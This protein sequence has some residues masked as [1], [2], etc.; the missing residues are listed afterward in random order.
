MILLLII[1][2][3][4]V[5]SCSLVHVAAAAVEHVVRRKHALKLF[6]GNTGNCSFCYRLLGNL[7]AF[8]RPR[9]GL[10]VAFFDLIRVFLVQATA[11]RGCDSGVCRTSVENMT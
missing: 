5:A 10:K 9:I 8:I 6:S 4:E 11:L 1:G 3:V 7:G 2:L